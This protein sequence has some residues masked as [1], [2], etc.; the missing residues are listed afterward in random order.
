MQGKYHLFVFDL[1]GTLIDSSPGII[2]AVRHTLQQFN[3]S[4][5]GEQELTSF[6]GPPLKK[7]FSLL[8]DVEENEAEDMVTAFRKEY[9]E[10]EILNARLY[11]GVMT[12]CQR[13]SEGGIKMAIAT[14]KPE[15]FAKR[16]IKHF[17][18]DG[19]IPVICGADMK[20]SLKKAD[21]IRKA[22]KL[23]EE[24]DN[25]AVVMVGDTL[26]D[27][28]AAKECGIDFIGVS[29]GFGFRHDSEIEYS[30]VLGIATTP[31]EILNIYG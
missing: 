29:Y 27:A 23:S 1:D 12:L 22:M 18:L 19:F 21:L 7:S 5:L 3:K 25:D 6:I 26:G 20:G 16:L 4:M 30:K 13:L 11:D 31:E 24:S 15:E 14:N 10:K 17:K 28:T 8:S 9:R 2:N